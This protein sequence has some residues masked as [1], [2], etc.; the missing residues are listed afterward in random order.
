MQ[1]SNTPMTKSSRHMGQRRGPRPSKESFASLL[2]QGTA[3]ENNHLF[4]LFAADFNEPIG[5]IWVNTAAQ[6]AFI[7]LYHR[8]RPARKR[9]WH[10]SV[11]GFGK[12]GDPARHHRNRLARFAHNQSA[13][14]L[15][16]KWAIW[17]QILRWFDVSLSSTKRAT[18]FVPRNQSTRPAPNKRNDRKSSFLFASI[19]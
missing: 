17:K 18:S 11:T 16:K 10:Q 2:P 19:T 12:V 4:S 6:K 9:L 3:T 15:Y 5:V 8:G 1:F 13:Y 14:Q 7:W